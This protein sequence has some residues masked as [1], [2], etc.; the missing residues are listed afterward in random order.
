MYVFFNKKSKREKQ[1]KQHAEQKKASE[2]SL[3][4]YRPTPTMTLGQNYFGKT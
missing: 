3:T 1:N 4:Q 2:K